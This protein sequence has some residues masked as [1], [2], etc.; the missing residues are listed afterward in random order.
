MKPGLT[1]LV[2][3]LDKSGSMTSLVNDTIGGFNSFVEKQKEVV[4]ECRIS[5]VLFDSQSHVLHNQV[6]LSQI[7]AMTSRE[8][9]AGG[10]TALIDA[11]GGAI[12]HVGNRIMH[13]REE[14]RP[15]KVMFVIITDGYENASHKYRIDQVHHMVQRQTEKYGWEFIFLGANIDAIG[16]AGRYGIGADRARNWVPDGEGQRVT[17]DSIATATRD[18]RNAPR[19]SR[20]REDWG[21]AIAADYVQRGGA[22]HDSQS[23]RHHSNPGNTDLSQQVFDAYNHLAKRGQWGQL[24]GMW[25]QDEAFARACAGFVKRGSKWTFLHQAAFYGDM[26]ACKTLTEL[27]ANL[28]ARTVHDETPV[29]VAVQRGFK[30]LAAELCR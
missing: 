14:K 28:N 19:G 5:T 13:T 15:E 30:G 6:E 8:Y 25:Q 3:I 7:P 9:Q 29:D 23:A 10:S 18:W 2:F 17:Y 21:D 12:N 26:A 1:E 4:G 24:M 20:L 11:L 22:R 16:E 27:G